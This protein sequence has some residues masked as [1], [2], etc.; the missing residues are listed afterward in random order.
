M[1]HEGGVGTRGTW[2]IDRGDLSSRGGHESLNFARGQ[3]LGKFSEIG[4]SLECWRESYVPFALE[5]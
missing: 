3:K 1:V 2:E 5:E 4:T